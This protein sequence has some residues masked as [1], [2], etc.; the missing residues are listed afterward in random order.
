MLEMSSLT[1]EYESN[2]YVQCKLMP[3]FK[4]I[5]LVVVNSERTG[6]EWLRILSGVAACNKRPDLINCNP[7]FYE[8]RAQPK[9]KDGVLAVQNKLLGSDRLLYGIKAGHPLRFLDDISVHEGKFG[10]L[11]DADYG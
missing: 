6:F 4:E 1:S 2:C 7:C 9:V 11:K 8:A 5:G 3:I 10:L